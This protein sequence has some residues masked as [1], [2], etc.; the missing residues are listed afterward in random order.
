MTA[1][2][3]AKRS[4]KTETSTKIHP[5]SVPGFSND[6][7]AL[8]VLIGKMR[9]DKI[10]DVLEG[11]RSE[12]NSQA[13]KDHERKRYQLSDHLMALPGEITKVIIAMEKIFA[14]CKPYLKRE[15]DHD[16]ITT[17]K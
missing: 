11:F 12:I 4:I 5:V 8:G 16:K 3:S 9:Y 14:L 15:L 17:T 7:F 13:K 2:K 6:N 10:I 1:K